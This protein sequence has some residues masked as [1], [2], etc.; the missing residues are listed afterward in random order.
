[1]RKLLA[2]ILLFSFNSYAVPPV[3]VNGELQSNAFVQNI[4]TPNNQATKV[5]GIDTRLETGNTNLLI[6][7]SFEHSTVGTGWSVTNATGT[8]NTTAQVEGK[9]ALS[10]SLSGALA[11][12]QDS[13][14]NATNLVGL[15][16]VASIKIK[17]SD[18]SGLKVCVRNAGVTSSTLCVS[19][20]ADGAWKRVSIPFIMTATSNGI[21]IT[22]AG[23]TGTVLIDDA[24]VG[25]SDP[26]QDFSTLTKDY[27]WVTKTT[28]LSGFGTSPS[29]TCKYRRRSGTLDAQCFGVMGTAP[30]GTATL[31]LPDSL[32]I[33]TARIIASNTTSG[34]GQKIGTSSQQGASL[35]YS[36]VVT[37]TGTSATNIYFANSI[38]GTAA[39][40]PANPFNGGVSTSIS[41]SVPISGWSDYGVI[42]G[43]F[44]G[45]PSVPGVS[46]AV[47]TFSFAYAGATISTPCSA[48]P[49][50]LYNKIGTSPTSMTWTS[51]GAVNINLNK[52]YSILNCMIVVGGTASAPTGGLKNT[53]ASCSSCN[54]L[55]I[56]TGDYNSIQN[57]FGN[58][59]CQG[60]Y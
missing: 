49:C 1:M 55:S 39:L 38:N 41:F 34:A 43:S 12:T 22:S 17:S 59:M 53:A 36:N 29:I 60:T 45:V 18:V 23:T 52:T 16:G 20:A 37:A 58:F 7:P 30:S 26:F 6:N 51:T 2:T 47:D 15:Q 57:T 25:T 9:K 31:T 28:T 40:V 4:K 3:A 5:G 50:T 44:G 42:V 24:F 27:D 56:S 19:I 10:L 33:D 32:S 21:A 8:A 14:V 46:G 35:A 54:L 48:S 11:V 13:T